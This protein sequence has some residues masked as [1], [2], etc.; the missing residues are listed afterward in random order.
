MIAYQ[1]ALNLLLGS[2]IMP[3]R[4][5]FLEEAL[6]CV[7]AKPVTSSVDIPAFHNSAMDG[8]ALRCELL[9][10]ASPEQPVVLKIDGS[11]AAGDSPQTAGEGAW[12][13]MTGAAVPSGYD[14]VVKIEDV[15]VQEGEVS[16]TQPAI[17]GQNIRKIGQDFS[18]GQDV[19]HAGTRL[20]PFHM[21]ALATIGEAEVEIF[22]KPRIS[23]FCTG[24][25]LVDDLSQ[26]LQ[27]GQIRN[28]NGPLLRSALAQEGYSAHY[29]GTIPDEPE[30]FEKCL[31]ERL[32][33]SDILISTGAVSAGKYD[34]IPD[35]VRKMGADM[36]F[37]KVRIQPGK[38]IFYAR[39]PTGQHFFGLPGNP[40][41]SAIGLRFFIL[42]LLRHLQGMPEEAP[43]MCRLKA[44]T[45]GKA[46]MRL[47]RKAYMQVTGDGSHQVEIL[48]GQESFKVHP[49]LRANCWAV[50]GE[51]DAQL[52]AGDIVPV[53]P[54]FTNCAEA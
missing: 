49:M 35:V 50:I 39:F 37:H 43:K 34:F 26:P 28:S 12:E 48:D 40:I 24:R 52:G 38:P 20:G 31:G 54:L 2:D 6:G 13:I 23:L 53:Y 16:F 27:P 25:E 15:R 29:G 42:P 44:D 51:K 9:K 3:V 14:G 18:H 7:L 41:S 30:L 1:E 46:G 32:P 36:L 8:F 5:L 19:A 47:F 11:T 4:R 10:K 33:Q 21:M 17:V 22:Q 45:K